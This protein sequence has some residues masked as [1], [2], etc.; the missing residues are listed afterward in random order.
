MSDSLQTDADKALALAIVNDF[1]EYFSSPLPLTEGSRYTLPRAL[2]IVPFSP[3]MGGLKIEHFADMFER[4]SQVLA[5]S[6]ESGA[7]DFRHRLAE[8]EAEIWVSGNIAAVLVGWSASMDGR[9]DFVHTVNLCTLHRLPHESSTNGNPWRI[10][11]LIDMNHLKPEVP[12]PPVETGP[13]SEIMAPY[14]ALLAHIEARDWDAIPPLL[15]PGAGATIA[16][17]SEAPDTFMWPEFIK[18]LQ[19]EAESSP[20]TQKKL[21]NCE[22]RRCD[23]LAFVWAPFVLMVD[24]REH[25]EGVSVCSFRLEEG[26]WLISGLQETSFTK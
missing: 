20:A 24:G 15:L 19:V 10:S 8:P 11:G 18:R 14:E 17:D 23:D 3:E 1:H 2:I 21:L 16:Q 13:L 22:A 7:K 6:Y 9:G 4:V 26:Q 25:A 12:A 5:K